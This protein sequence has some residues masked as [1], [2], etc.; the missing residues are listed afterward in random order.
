MENKN[1]DNKS[2]EVQDIIDRMPT[3]WAQYI[4][5]TFTGMIILMF[6]LSFTIEYSDTINGEINITGNIAPIKMV[7]QSAGRIRL[8]KKDNA[9][10]KKGEVL[11][12]IETGAQY[13]D[14]QILSK[15]C[16]YKFNPE[17]ILDLPSELVLGSMNSAY[18]D[19]VLAYNNYD[20]LR[21]TKV[22]ENLRMSLRNQQKANVGV[23]NNVQN[24]I[25]IMKRLFKIQ[26][27]QFLKDSLLFSAGAIS[28]IAFENKKASLMEFEKSMVELNSMRMSKNAEI[29]STALELAKV[30]VNVSED[31]RA[32]FNTLVLKF[33]ALCNEEK[34]WREKFLLIAPSDGI[35]EYIGFWREND[36]IKTAEDLFSIVPKQN[37]LVGEMTISSYGAGKVKKGQNVIIQLNDFPYTEFGHINGVVSTITEVSHEQT[38]NGNNISCYRVKIDLPNDIK[39]NYN[40]LL[41]INYETKGMGKIITTPHTLIERLFDNLNSIRKN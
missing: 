31:L 40:Q 4:I 38:I 9:Y 10:V 34:Q 3:G 17:T 26:K 2:E 29:S 25:D 5:V 8:I 23:Y 12:Y 20:K 30:D 33:N 32:S 19:F 6:I 18:N 35:L 37:H 39:S 14:M 7:S 36:F 16:K 1:I 24:E 22:Y 27:E 28:Q 15:I 11:A 21:K 41:T 13:N